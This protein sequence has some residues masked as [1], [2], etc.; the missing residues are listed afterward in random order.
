MLQKKNSSVKENPDYQRLDADPSYYKITI[1]RGLVASD[2]KE[3]IFISRI[4]GMLDRYMSCDSRNVFK[5]DFT[6]E[7]SGETYIAFIPKNHRIVTYD[8]DGNLKEGMSAKELLEHY[9]P[10]DREFGEIKNLS[11]NMHQ[12][13]PAREPKNK[14]GKNPGI[15][16]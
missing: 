16:R 10:V 3:G 2:K 11:K 7:G 6:E 5:T 1:N 15:K 4:P 12:E 9:S 14:A 13:A 8:K